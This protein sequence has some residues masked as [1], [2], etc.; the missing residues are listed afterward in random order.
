MAGPAGRQGGDGEIVRVDG[1]R[2]NVRFEPG[3]RISL[4]YNQG[5]DFSAFDLPTTASGGV[6]SIGY[7]LTRQPNAAARSAA[8]VT[9]IGGPGSPVSISG[10]NLQASGSRRRVLRWY[11]QAYDT[12]PSSEP[13]SKKSDTITIT[14][15][16]N[17]PSPIVFSASPQVSVAVK[18][19]GFGIRL[20]NASGGSGSFTYR[21]EPERGGRSLSE[22][23]FSFDGRTN[24]LRAS[25]VANLPGTHLFRHIADD[26]GTGS[27]EQRTFRIKIVVPIT[28][29]ALRMNFAGFDETWVVGDFNTLYF[30]QRASGGS[31]P[32]TYTYTPSISFGGDAAAFS[33]NA[34]RISGTPTRAGIY[35]GVYIVRDQS[36]QT[37][38]YPVVIR[39]VAR[40]SF[41]GRTGFGP[42]APGDPVG[43]SLPRLQNVPAGASVT[44]GLSAAARRSLGAIG[45]S[46]SGT[47]L[48]G[49][50]KSRLTRAQIS[51]GVS[52][53]WTATFDGRSYDTACSVTLSPAAVSLPSQPDLTLDENTSGTRAVAAATGGS[54]SYRYTLGNSAGTG[55]YLVGSTLRWST[56]LVESDLTV[57]AFLNVEDLVTGA[58][59]TRHFNITVRNIAVPEGSLNLAPYVYDAADNVLRSVT[60]P[61]A[62]GTLAGAAAYSAVFTSGVRAPAVEVVNGTALLIRQRTSDSRRNA[63]WTRTAVS[64]AAVAVASV[65]A[66]VYGRFRYGNN[67]RKRFGPEVLGEALPPGYGETITPLGGKTVGGRYAS[68]RVKTQFAGGSGLTLAVSAA[69]R[70]TIT[71]T[72]ANASSTAVVE[73]TDHPKSDGTRSTTDLE[74]TLTAAAAPFNFPQPA[75]ELSVEEG[76]QVDWEVPTPER[77]AVQDLQIGTVTAGTLTE[78]VVSSLAQPALVDGAWRL[79]GVVTARPGTNDYTLRATSSTAAT[80]DADLRIIVT[81]Q[82]RVETFRTPCGIVVA[83]RIP[84]TPV[85]ER[86]VRHTLPDPETGIGAI[87]SFRPSKFI[88]SPGE[89][90]TFDWEVLTRFNRVQIAEVDLWR[91]DAALPLCGGRPNLAP[92]LSVEHSITAGYEVQA[93]TIEGVWPYVLEARRAGFASVYAYAD[94]W[95]VWVLVTRRAVARHISI[96][97][98]HL[99]ARFP[100][101]AQVA[102]LGEAPTGDQLLR[103]TPQYDPAAALFPDPQL[104]RPAGGPAAPDPSTTG[105][106]DEIDDEYCAMN[107]DDPA[108]GGEGG[109]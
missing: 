65:T 90:I 66:V 76:E 10:S 106:V 24:S 14:I 87:Q 22:L 29:H 51:R 37:A 98:S 19:T 46:V 15:T 96:N 17:P 11:W 9:Q 60:L 38:S 61:S 1:A 16:I 44:Y 47:R 74:V 21:L 95:V 101:I 2:S 93:P 40:P 20:N 84:R 108:C 71:G 62:T 41:T 3:S 97:K 72:P 91:T 45:L 109:G 50:I 57:R 73:A 48:S 8:G 27:S 25:R 63:V 23:G 33:V 53:T 56:P 36:G 35:R 99:E 43:A 32:G 4:T 86:S 7:R 49:R 85:L 105:G 68:Y 94:Y 77:G 92:D 107:P 80:A 18:R 58:L 30:T 70:I 28:A 52:F 31:G 6:G 55:V 12:D 69:G 34:S 89:R 39:V 78:E 102:Y 75:Y 83:T 82:R 100:A 103:L 81:P 67:G 13:G 54:G 5:D 79:R 64:G 88:V 26:A 59:V 42:F 104:P